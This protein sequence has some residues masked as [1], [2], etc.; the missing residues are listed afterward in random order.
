MHLFNINLWSLLYCK[1][2]FMVL[3][4]LTSLPKSNSRFKI[5]SQEKSLNKILYVWRNRGSQGSFSSAVHA[6]A[7]SALLFDG[8]C[9][10]IRHTFL[11]ERKTEVDV[12][13]L[14]TWQ[15]TKLSIAVLKA[16]LIFI[17]PCC[18]IIKPW[19]CNVICC[20]RYVFS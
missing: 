16:F 11:S 10:T 4:F 18:F 6:N 19:P 14:F 20:F 9:I 15:I 1:N 8:S 7:L 5:T 13:E 17:N 3:C 2:C 12:G